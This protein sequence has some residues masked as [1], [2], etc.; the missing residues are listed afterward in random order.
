MEAL[1]NVPGTDS[2]RAEGLYPGAESVAVR[3]PTAGGGGGG[4]GRE[5]QSPLLPNS[6]CVLS[7]LPTAS[8]PQ[9]MFIHSFSHSFM[10]K[11]F[12]NIYYDAEL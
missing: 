12:I 6:S 5:S 4:R 3:G 7:P 1:Q 2:V 10:Y 8:F 9:T 11:V